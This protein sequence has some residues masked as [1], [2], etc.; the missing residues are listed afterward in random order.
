MHRL[1]IA[2]NNPV[3]TNRIPIRDISACNLVCKRLAL[4][5]IKNEIIETAKDDFRISRAAERDVLWEERL[6]CNRIG[7]GEGGG[8]E[9]PVEQSRFL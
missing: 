8:E 6:V 9:L 7:G 4:S 3:L 5:R 1:G 2:A